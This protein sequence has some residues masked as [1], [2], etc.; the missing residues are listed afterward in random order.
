MEIIALP[1]FEKRFKKYDSKLQARIKEEI[2]AI[3]DTPEIGEFK[4]GDIAGIQVHK[5]KVERQLYLL[6]Y[7]V[8]YINN[9]ILLY[10]IGLHEGF[11]K[12]LKR[13]LK[14]L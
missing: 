10:T 14:S 9:T 13:Y 3:I 4:K 2:K 11:Y 1:K 8:S 7:E 6:A 12:E 5:F